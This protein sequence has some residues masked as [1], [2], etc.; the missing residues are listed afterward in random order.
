MPGNVNRVTDEN[1]IVRCKYEYNAFGELLHKSETPGYA[2]RFGFQSNWITLRD[3]G[4]R[5]C[6]SPT[7]VY[8]TATGRFLQRDP[9]SGLAGDY[10]YAGNA[11]VGAADP[12]GLEPTPAY[13]QGKR[14][15]T[16]AES[17]PDEYACECP[18]AHKNFKYVG[19]RRRFSPGYDTYKDALIAAVHYGSRILA[20]GPDRRKRAM[21]EVGGRIF[22]D[23][24][25]C[26]FHFTQPQL[27]AKRHVDWGFIPYGTMHAGGWHIHPSS[28]PTGDDRSLLRKGSKEWVYVKDT[29]KL[30]EISLAE[31][32]AKTRP[33]KLPSTSWSF[34]DLTAYIQ[35]RKLQ[36][37]KGGYWDTP[38]VYKRMFPHSGTAPENPPTV[39]RLDQ[40]REATR[41][42][43]RQWIDDPEHGVFVY[44]DDKGNALKTKLPCYVLNKGASDTQ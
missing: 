1:G 25:T 23:P 27:G 38:E 20:S 39:G 18:R 12:L 33:E 10:L 36:Q 41:K 16:K 35:K 8:D 14:P 28:L 2:G 17:G 30:Y 26:R 34:S 6:L 40:D 31:K 11:P 19:N 9:L 3:S 21:K 4:G 32:L 13:L 44:E 42:A 5:L 37:P 24:C 7:R 43:L 29:G 15:M 22:Y